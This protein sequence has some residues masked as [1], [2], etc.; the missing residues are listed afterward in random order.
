[1]FQNSFGKISRAF[2]IFQLIR[3]DFFQNLKRFELFEIILSYIM[4]FSEECI[5]FYDLSEDFKA[6]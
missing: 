5:G 1:M 6:I 3:M 4:R 2:K